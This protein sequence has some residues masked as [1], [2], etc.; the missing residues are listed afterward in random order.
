M[1][2]VV[3]LDCTLCQDNEYNHTQNKSVPGLYTPGNRCTYAILSGT[4]DTFGVTGPLPIGL[5]S[6]RF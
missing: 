6:W 4:I 2:V 3:A 5:S 1:V